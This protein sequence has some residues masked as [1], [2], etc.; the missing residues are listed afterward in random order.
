MAFRLGESIAGGLP[1][2]QHAFDPGACPH[3]M[4]A[5]RRLAEALHF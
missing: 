4:P 1:L 3:F 2:F 5:G